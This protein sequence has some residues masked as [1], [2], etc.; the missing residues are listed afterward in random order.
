MKRADIRVERAA[1]P[2]TGF[3][4]RLVQAAA[5][6]GLL[7]I[8]REA[9]LRQRE[10]TLA[11]QRVLIT[12]GSRGLG[13]VLAREFAAEG[14]RVV[15]CARDE[16]GLAAARRDLERRG[17]LVLAISCDVSDRAQVEEMVR[18]VEADAGPIDILVNNAG[19][20]Q[21]GPVGA[22]DVEDFE[23]IMAANFYGAL[24]TIFAVLPHMRRRRRGRIVNI[25]SIGGKV[26]VPHLLPYSASKF[27]LVGLSE[28][29]RAELARAGIRV[30]T[31]VPGLMRTGSPPNAF[32]RG[33]AAREWTWFSVADSLPLLTTGA[34]RAARR[35]VKATR[36]GEAEVTLTVPALVQRIANGLFPG[37][38]ADALGLINRLLPS[39]TRRREMRGMQLATPL[40]PSLLTT[41]TNRAARRN[42]EYSGEEQPSPRH[43]RQAGI[44]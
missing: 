18:Q 10:T 12:G 41:L 13:L 24:H 16:Q 21:V 1:A 19:I 20:I 26:A 35:I 37:A 27:A 44:A 43:A 29:L 36:R 5:A 38:M 33:D 7:A 15:I 3:A 42:H 40:A 30:T 11:G 14:C 17:A 28:G 25:T 4:G 23:R 6:A 34:E 9:L 39:V 32:F 8:A 31:I 22:M 2:A